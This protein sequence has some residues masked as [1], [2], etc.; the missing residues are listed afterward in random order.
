MSDSKVDGFGAL[1]K[2]FDESTLSLRTNSVSS[3]A[4]YITVVD[5]VDSNTSYVGEAM[6]G[7]ATTS[8]S[9]RI[10]KLTTS[11]SVTSK[12]YADGDTNFDNIWSLRASLSYS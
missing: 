8:P 1:I 3:A 12:I 4:S 11:G 10:F 5:E 9:W 7:T 6:P 2:A